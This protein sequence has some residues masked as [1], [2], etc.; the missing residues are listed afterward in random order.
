MEDVRRAADVGE[1]YRVTA[2]ALL[3]DDPR[4]ALGRAVGV[5]LEPLADVDDR[6]DLERRCLTAD[7]EGV[8]VRRGPGLVAGVLRMGPAANCGGRVVVEVGDG[9]RGHRRTGHPL[10]DVVDVLDRLRR[11]RLEAGECG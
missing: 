2:T 1:A 4:A 10:L 9:P 7:V 8:A 11:R 6:E 5:A 3:A